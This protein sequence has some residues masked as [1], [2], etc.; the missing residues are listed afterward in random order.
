MFLKLKFILIALIVSLLFVN[1]SFTNNS[2]EN[3]AN[4]KSLKINEN[5]KIVA[6][7]TNIKGYI[8]SDYRLT[9]LAL[10]GYELVNN[11]LNDNNNIFY[12]N[13]YGYYPNISVSTKD[14]QCGMG[15]FLGWLSILPLSEKDNY[16]NY[17]KKNKKV[18]EYRFTKVDSTQFGLRAGIGLIT[19]MTPFITAGNLHTRMFDK[20]GFEDAIKKTNIEEYRQEL[21]KKL[22]KIYSHGIVLV[23]Y[24]DKD[25]LSD[26]LNQVYQELLENKDK[27][28]GI[29]F[30]D[31]KTKKLFSLNIFNKKEDVINA[32]LTQINDLFHNIIKTENILNYED[33]ITAIPKEISL[34]E[35]PKID[36]I[37]KSE[38]ETFKAFEKRLAQTIKQ[39]E[40][41][42]KNIQREYIQ[43]VENRNHFI[44][45]LQKEYIN[46]I[47]N[48]AD[49]KNDFLKEL[50][51]EI[52]LL[53]KIL[54]LANSSGYDAKR[55]KYDAEKEK[56]HF[57][58][59][60]RDDNFIKN[61]VADIPPYIARKIKQD[62]TFKIHPNIKYEN[63]KLVLE[64]FDIIET[65]SGNKYGLKYTNINYPSPLVSLKIDNEL[66][67]IKK[68]ASIKFQEYK[69][70]SLPIIDHSKKEIWYIDVVK[71]VNGKVPKW[72]AE[73]ISNN[74]MGY[75]DGDT[76]D[77]AKTNARKD[78]SYMMN[79]SLKSS[80]KLIKEIGDIKNY[81]NI[82][83]TVNQLTNAELNSKDYSLYKQEKVDGRWYVGLI[84]NKK[85]NEEL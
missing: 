53:S 24:L 28:A 76:L 4:K 84:L 41:N 9:R 44:D 2:I 49:L 7:S 12:I 65:S 31:K 45:N 59:F 30:L 78:L 81:K 70:K 15:S 51:I 50:S 32:T 13:Q 22:S 75:G 5:I 74:L 79:L 6:S 34:P 71:R 66:D 29:V 60:T 72:F 80:F 54:F 62:K 56:L 61:A 36:R 46:Y 63:K 82:K 47:D 35:L 68:Q 85:N 52:P 3:V 17:T 38:F 83:S 8:N 73:P 19:F 23:V 14:I 21:Y 18:C 27:I 55:F 16:I 20:E 48:K 77:E 43:Q 42:I 58:I 39:R 69:Q 25:S 11:N 64:S 37:V 26:D 1:C 10:N 33:I 40:N 57:K 67:I